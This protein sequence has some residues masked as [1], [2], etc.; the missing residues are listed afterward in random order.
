MHG[1][2]TGE[3]DAGGMGATAT[4]H[5]R[6]DLMTTLT[7]SPPVRTTTVALAL[8]VAA[9]TP[10]LALKVL[11]LSGSSIGLTAEAAS[12][13]SSSRFVVG[14]AITVAL[15]LVA[16]LL[17]WSLTR[18]WAR[19]VPARLL[20]VLGAGAPG[21]LAPVL[22]GMPLGQVAE[23]MTHGRPSFDG[24]GME[25]WVFACVYGG[26][27]VLGVAL[28]V[29]LGQY[30]VDRWGHRFVTPPRVVRS[31]TFAVGVLGL[32]PFGLAMVWWGLAG[33]GTLGPQG[34]TAPA[35]RT[36][37]VVTGVLALAALLAPLT[38]RTREV[39]P[40]AARARWLVV[41]VGCCTAALQGPTQLLLA[42]GGD[43]QPAIAAIALL[44]TPGAIVHG[45]GLLGAR[46]Q[47][48]AGG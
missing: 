19:D 23:T 40:G 7:P 13:M 38:V 33:P 32:T 44:A 1:P 15:E 31:W 30:A 41:W 11:W 43:V 46:P 35:Q 27:V 2:W 22:V 21:L 14:N 4:A 9:V 24:E 36:V 25:S 26:F 28:A 20:A 34:M 3:A 45:L 29:I 39:P 6:E 12:T 16:L 5:P 47:K 48:G 17:A 8:A 10:Y 42:H 18:P 37:L